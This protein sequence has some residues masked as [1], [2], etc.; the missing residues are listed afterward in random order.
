MMR[1]ALDGLGSFFKGA[2]DLRALG[3]RKSGTFQDQC[4]FLGQYC[5]IFRICSVH[6]FYTNNTVKT[7]RFTPVALHGDL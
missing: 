1:K 4:S 7:L 5:R 3:S 6:V 2:A